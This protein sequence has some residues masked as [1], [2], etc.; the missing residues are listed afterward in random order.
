MARWAA[1]KTVENVEDGF[2]I[3]SFTGVVAVD[4]NFLLG[5]WRV[6]PSLNTV[7]RNRTIAH[8]EP[9]VMEVLVCLAQHPGESV[10]KERVLQAVWPDTF[11]SDDVLKR[12]IHELRRVFEDDAREPK[13]IQTIAKR[14][15]RLVAS[16]GPADG[17]GAATAPVSPAPPRAK[18]LA[19]A[20]V[21]VALGV[22]NASG[23]LNWMGKARTL[24]TSPAHLE[25]RRQNISLDVVKKR[26]ARTMPTDP[27]LKKAH[28]TGTLGDG[29]VLSTKGDL[30]NALVLVEI[31]PTRVEIRFQNIPPDVAKTRVIRAVLP[32]YPALAKEARITGTVEIGLAISP[33]GD[34]GSARVLI[35]HPMLVT[36]ALEAIRRWQFEPN[37][38]QGELTWSRMRALIRFSADGT[39]AVAFAP[40]LLADS[41]GDPGA[42]RDELREAATQPTVAE[43]R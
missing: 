18:L 15:Y 8:L 36:P 26:P 43:A 9:K 41:F 40:P 30:A 37:R 22:L 24:E 34:V 31:P 32:A 25:P 10:S 29:P 38:A 16:V 5:P 39:T 35:G 33:L 17:N 4:G 2:I 14:G 23:L 12:S 1:W 6:E 20:A 21:L 19:V 13:F 27:D 11:V 42:R 7:S 28:L 3:P